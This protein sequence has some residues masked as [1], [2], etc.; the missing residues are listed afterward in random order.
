MKINRVNNYLMLQP[1]W[2]KI[3]FSLRVYNNRLKDKPKNRWAGDLSKTASSR[4]TNKI[5]TP[6]PLKKYSWITTA[7][8]P[9]TT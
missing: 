9:A 6:D 1:E 2:A 5:K 8:L 3:L 4:V 7:P